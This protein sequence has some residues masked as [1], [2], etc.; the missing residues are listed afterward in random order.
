[1]AYYRDVR[2]HLEALDRAGKLVRVKRPINKD[3][4]L[5]PL[6]R[7]QF[8][9]LPESERRAFLFERVTDAR[10]R[11]YDMPVALGCYAGSLDIYALGMGCGRDEIFDKWTRA[12]A[13]PI[14]PVVV[15]T[16]P[17][18]EQVI[19]GDDLRSSGLDRL[20]VPISTPG[21]D[22]GPYTT[23]SHWVTRDAETG[24]INVGN[25]RGQVKAADRLGC[26]CSNPVGGLR[27][28]WHK[29]RRRGEPLEAAVVMGV[30]PNIS[31]A[32]VARVAPDVS[33]YDVAGAI[34]GEPVELVRCRTV[35]LLVPARA[36]I[37][38]EGVIPTDQLEMEG[39]FGEFPG[40]MAQPGY[41]YFMDV[42]C[43][44][45]RRDPI[46]VGF[47]SQ[48]PPSESSKLRGVAWE[49]VI[50]RRL[51]EAGVDSVRDVA[52]HESSGSWGYLVVRI[53][54]RDEGDFERVV[55]ALRMGV[56]A[57]KVLVVVDD[58]ID[59]R[60]ADSVNWAL[61]F[62]MQPHRDVRV[63]DASPMLLD[64]SLLPAEEASGRRNPLDRGDRASVLAIDATRPWP[65]PPLSL[66]RR[67]FMER[68]RQIWAELGLP[69]LRL[70]EPW[71][72]ADLGFWSERSRAE[73]ELA[74]CGRHLE[75]G[76]QAARG[77]R[78]PE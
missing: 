70:K 72:G 8:R 13:A 78:R 64:P 73:A 5:H 22:N 77:R 49:G 65:Y 67:D 41:S 51:L 46:Y 74:L 63:L 37:V 61:S 76:E 28:H 60:D 52:V 48:F 42:T 16:G 12:Q 6:V 32:A 45:M 31:Y 53:A 39:P 21:F 7:L 47:L 4:E 29:R 59:A 33:E 36:E 26:L 27:N 14:P 24:V 9:G 75:I 15:D 69:P 19:A 34:A 2:E 20:P 58:D 35:D 68:A 40:Y 50:R 43:I 55:G 23:A 66:P 25:Y 62:R 1:L 3:T 17:V 57:G 44:T 11:V 30:S 18:H 10:G 56:D 38:I 71:H 54:K